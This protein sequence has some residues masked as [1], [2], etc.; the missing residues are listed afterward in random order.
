MRA[1]LTEFF[2][3]VLVGVV[4]LVFQLSRMGASVLPFEALHA[5][6]PPTP[7]ATVRPAP[8]PTTRLTRPTAIASSQ[9]SGAVCTPA[10]PRFASGMPTLKSA[11]GDTMGEPQECEHAVDDQG[12]T[13]QKTSTGL[14]YYR[15]ELNVACFTTGWDHWAWT[16]RGLV[17]WTGESID[18][19][20]DAALA[21][22]SPGP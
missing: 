19:P 10:R 22:P 1:R 21:I 16:P 5:S 2:P 18:P 9:P 12:N 7:V 4:L 15:H 14:A 11:L 8:S 17:T 13:Q 20:P 6:S 3:L